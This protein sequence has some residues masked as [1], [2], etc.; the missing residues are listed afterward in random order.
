MKKHVSNVSVTCFFISVGCVMRVCRP[1]GDDV[2]V[3][4]ING[5]VTSRINDRNVLLLVGLPRTTTESTQQVQNSAARV[6]SEVITRNHVH[7]LFS[8]SGC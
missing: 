2:A 3:R 5:L 6:V 1:V 4:L 8:C 7:L